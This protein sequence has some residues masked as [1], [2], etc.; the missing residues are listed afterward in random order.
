MVL[1][2]YVL[3]ARLLWRSAAGLSVLC[4][5]LTVIQAAATTAALITTGRLIG[6][7][8][9][10][11]HAGPGSAAA[12]RTWWWLVATA[13][14]FV[15]GPVASAL[16]GM[17]GRSVAARYLVTVFDMTAEAGLHPYGLSPLE[18]PAIAARFD[19]LVEATNNWLFVQGVEATW[20]VLG[21]RLGGVGSFVVLATW[22]W[23]APFVG[24]AGWLVMSRSF[25]R[26]INTLFDEIAD[27][28]G[29]G[30]RKATYFRTLLTSDPAAKEVRLF[31]LARWL[32]DHYT[33]AWLG[34]MR[35]VWR[36]RS[37]S[38][39]VT[40]STLVFGVI[41]SG[42]VFAVL[43]AD[44]WRGAVSVGSVVTLAQ[45]VLALGAFGPVGDPQT[46]M[47][48][49]T[50]AAAK[51]VALR[52][53]LG[54]SRLPALNHAGRTPAAPA[55]TVRQAVSVELREV[56]FTY[57]SRDEPTIDGLSLQIPAGQSV[58]VVGV[59]GAGKSTLIKLLCGLYRPEAGQIRLD[60]SDPGVDQQTRQRIAVIFQDFVHYPLP[61]RDNV[62]FGLGDRCDDPD[63]L[64]RALTAAGGTGLLERLDHG[65]DTV[66]SGEHEGGTDLSGGQWQLVALARALAA[67]E[68]GAGLLILDEPTAALDVRAEAALFDRFLQ[69]TRGV[70]TV[71]VSHRLS[72]VRHA[73]RIVVIDK[74][75]GGGA[76]VIED[77]GH[78]QLLAAGGAYAGLFKLQAA[79]FA[80]AGAAAGAGPDVSE[81]GATGAD[82]SEDGRLA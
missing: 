81:D 80:A 52:T 61:L 66:L 25:N 67:V 69:V 42:A 36:A 45:A 49:N 3:H 57:P 70:T 30:R 72:S 79:R 41:T 39:R 9:A 71:L 62:G 63:V 2:R 44:A 38:L 4:L 29:T 5:A 64:D 32:V 43:A 51:L 35:T 11:V 20:N 65:W 56:T 50:A 16:A 40:M 78:E 28:S 22:R 68:A 53:E 55:A 8:T 34:A 1:Q 19:G 26:Y 60:G 37:R 14:V 47:S 12:T 7:L 24:V 54:L 15:A 74:V 75:P 10:A 58:A 48:R 46:A 77:G 13:V 23:W 31:G 17:F 33:E 6:S 27:A 59:N 18:D 73:E 21:T 76:R 82:V